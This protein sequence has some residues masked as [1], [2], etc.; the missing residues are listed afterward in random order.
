MSILDTGGRCCIR[1]LSGSAGAPQADPVPPAST[2]MTRYPALNTCHE[3]DEEVFAHPRIPNA[4]VD[5]I[6]S[7]RSVRTELGRVVLAEPSSPVMVFETGLPTRYYLNPS[8]VNF[9]HLIPTR[10][11]PRA[12]TRAPPV[13]TGPS[14]S[15]RPYTVTRPAPTTSRPAVVADHRTYRLLQRATKRSTSS[16]SPFDPI[17]Q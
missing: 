11:G 5:A 16:G 3:E 15:P 2:P 10:R 12:R 4:R 8:E 7:T 1:Y 14:G 13:G 6:R 9:E 17:A